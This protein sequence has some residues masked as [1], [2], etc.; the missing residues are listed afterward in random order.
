MSSDPISMPIVE[1]PLYEKMF[2][3]RNN[4]FPHFIDDQ[5]RA[6]ES[7]YNIL[8]PIINAGKIDR[9]IDLGCGTGEII[10]EMK[11]LVDSEASVPRT[12]SFIGIDCDNSE[13][14]IAKGE[15]KRRGLSE[16]LFLCDS[17]ENFLDS[18]EENERDLSTTCLLM[19]GHTMPHFDWLKFKKNVLQRKPKYLFYDLFH[20]FDRVLTELESKNIDQ[21]VEE[22]KK[23]DSDNKVLYVT[24]TTKLS[25]EKINRAIFRYEYSN[26]FPSEIINNRCLP[27]KECKGAEC[28]LH[29]KCLELKFEIEPKSE[30]AVTQSFKKS[31]VINAMLSKMEYMVESDFTYVAGYGYM[32]G[33]FYVDRSHEAKIINNAYYSAANQLLY[34][35]F[36]ESRYS[37]LADMR[38]TANV[39]TAVIIKPFDSY[40][41]FAKYSDLTLFQKPGKSRSKRLIPDFDMQLD[42]PRYRSNYPMLPAPALHACLLGKGSLANVLPL[43][44]HEEI[45]M[46]ALDGLRRQMNKEKSYLRA[47]AQKPSDSS[48]YF[49]IPFFVGHLP[50]FCLL[51]DCGQRLPLQSTTPTLYEEHLRNWHEML[52]IN[53]TEDEVKKFIIDFVSLAKNN[54]GENSEQLLFG[55]IEQAKLKPWKSWLHSIPTQTV[56]ESIVLNRQ[57]R[58]Y[59]DIWN[60]AIKQVNLN[61]INKGSHWLQTVDFFGGPSHE[62]PVDTDACENIVTKMSR[63]LDPEMGGGISINIYSM[64]SKLNSLIENIPDTH[65]LYDAND[66]ANC[67]STWLLAQLKKLIENIEVNTWKATD[68]AFII[69]HKIKAIYCKTAANTSSN[70]RFTPLRICSFFEIYN[71]NLLFNNNIILNEVETDSDYKFSINPRVEM[72]KLPI[73]D[74]ALYDSELRK[75]ADII[76]HNAKKVNLTINH[77]QDKYSFALD[78]VLT[79]ALSVDSAGENTDR[80]C[81]WVRMNCGEPITKAVFD[82][83]IAFGIRIDKKGVQNGIMNSSENVWMQNE[84]GFAF[85][86]EV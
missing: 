16:I 59:G 63:L 48:L 2:Q 74:Y 71:Q 75:L 27:S 53:L 83:K 40:F 24:R 8:H 17:A 70:F 64:N 11:L 25:T 29:N 81:R 86:I 43:N 3:L 58:T 46:V 52:K 28:D 68:E 15:A 26:C 60:E 55:Y 38:Q 22:E 6:A 41:T 34:R 61:K 72:K 49:L 56:R 9:I 82:I 5:K 10:Q 4:L 42:M 44:K 77:D 79:K 7:I 18:I 45:S 20:T 13:I 1:S 73:I 39:I 14:Q 85:S 54:L 57:E 19:T 78:I 84:K 21:Y 66:R 36:S 37:S 76:A 67:E 50:L 31:N 35:L 47:C 62:G 33:Y 30:F 80:L 12:I 51:V 69:F 65:Y 32:K 23:F